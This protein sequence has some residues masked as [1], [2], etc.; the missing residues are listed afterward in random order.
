LN[1]FENIGIH[2]I[3]KVEGLSFDG[4][5]FLPSEKNLI[6]VVF[7]S[8]NLRLF[9]INPTDFTVIQKNYFFLN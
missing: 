2:D 4:G 6:F 8:F 9:K 1:D 5:S 7:D 3:E